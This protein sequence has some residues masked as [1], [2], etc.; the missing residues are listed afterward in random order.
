MSVCPHCGGHLPP[1]LISKGSGNPSLPEDLRL[2]GAAAGEIPVKLSERKAIEIDGR[3]VEAELIG[4]RGMVW[5]RC[6]ARKPATCWATGV[7][8]PIS[9][10]A[11]RPITNGKNRPRRV[12][13]KVWAHL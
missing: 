12:D 8:I 1:S 7:T 2:A 4:W 5:S 10:P 6:L 13:A 9:G 3:E 11:W